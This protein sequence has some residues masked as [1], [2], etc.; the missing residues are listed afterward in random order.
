LEPFARI[1]ERPFNLK[2]CTPVLV[3]RGGSGRRSSSLSPDKGSNRGSRNGV[4]RGS[5]STVLEGPTR[6]LETDALERPTRR[7]LH[8][9]CDGDVEGQ[10]RHR[11]NV[12]AGRDLSSGAQS[13]IRRLGAAA[14]NLSI[15]SSSVWSYRTTSHG[16]ARPP[17]RS[18]LRTPCLAASWNQAVLRPTNSTLRLTDS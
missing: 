16:V 2:L 10:A 1:R 4:H 7:L 3:E 11:P 8:A 17:R 13:R 14:L 15:R 9:S 18:L 5:S 6:H 12:D